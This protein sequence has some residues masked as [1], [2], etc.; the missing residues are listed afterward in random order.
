[1]LRHPPQRLFARHRH[2]PRGALTGLAFV[3]MLLLLV[4]PTTGRLLGVLSA[5]SYG[6]PHAM[7]A[8]DHAAMAMAMPEQ[9]AVTTHAAR[10]GHPA[11]PDGAGPHADNGTCP[12]CP[13]LASMLALA[14]FVALLAA[15]PAHGPAHAAR[16]LG[17]VTGP[18]CGL[19]ARG[20]PAPV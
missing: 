17:D 4:M 7:T 9:S 1:M 14:L 5:G 20:P 10:A 16:G 19:G 11:P 6:M 18:Y 12:Y 2:A 3:A 15:A 8:L 13:L